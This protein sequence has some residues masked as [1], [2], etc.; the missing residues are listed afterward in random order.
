MTA[1]QIIPLFPLG[2]VT[3]PGA[4]TPLHI[5]EERYKEMIARCLAENLEFGIVWFNG[6]A[7][8]NAGC[9]VRIL[10]V[11]KRYDDGRMDILT[12][13]RQRFQILEIIEEK[14]YLEA[15]VLF[16]E[17][18]PEVMA[19]EMAQLAAKGEAVFK[20]LV[21]LLSND[22]AVDGL[23]L[24]DPKDLSFTIAGFDGF[25]AMEKQ[26][27]LEMTSTRNRL[28]KGIAALEKVVARVRLTSEVERI[29]GGNGRP[30]EGLR[31]KLGRFNP[32]GE[33]DDRV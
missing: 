11:T 22:E 8:S 30:S 13:G 6:E 5:F 7:I 25:G 26:A 10:E 24:S 28:D 21:G 20:E 17:D 33:A 14:A 1:S 18:A 19:A 32:E 29:V 31:F 12:R 16:F 15:R 2:I 4:A 23:D 9:T 3:L 27:F